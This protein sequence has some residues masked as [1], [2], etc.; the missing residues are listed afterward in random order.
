MRWFK[1]KCFDEQPRWD[2][3]VVDVDATSAEEAVERI[4]GPDVRQGGQIGELRAQV[5]DVSAPQSRK[6]FYSRN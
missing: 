4:C 5:W 1:L 6:M 3:K 2:R